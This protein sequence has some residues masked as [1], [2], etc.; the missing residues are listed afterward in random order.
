MS[1]ILKKRARDAALPQ[2]EQFSSHSLRRGLATS[3]SRHGAS[4]PAI[5]RQGRW[6]NMNTVMEYIEATQRFED[7]AAASVLKDI[8]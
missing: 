2:A 3:A 4:L 5:M 8:R 1:H 7:N 6:K